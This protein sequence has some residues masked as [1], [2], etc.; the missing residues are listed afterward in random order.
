MPPRLPKT[1]D[2]Q[3]ESDD[4]RQPVASIA[5]YFFFDVQF[6]RRTVLVDLTQGSHRLPSKVSPPVQAQTSVQNGNA[7]DPFISGG[8]AGLAKGVCEVCVESFAGHPGGKETRARR[9]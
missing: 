6:P 3:S 8:S 2:R 1:C 7:V 4:S 5:P 9:S